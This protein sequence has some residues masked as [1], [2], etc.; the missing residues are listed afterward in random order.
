MDLLLSYSGRAEKRSLLPILED[1]WVDRCRFGRPRIF[2][3]MTL[4]SEGCRLNYLKTE[5]T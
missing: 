3:K 2:S 5:L 4:T 1:F